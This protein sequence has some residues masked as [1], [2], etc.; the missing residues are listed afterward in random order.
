MKT[1]N[2][3]GKEYITVNERVLAFLETYPNWSIHTKLIRADADE[4]LMITEIIDDNGVLRSTGHAYE[5]ADG[6]QINKTSHVEN[7]ETSAVGRA[8]GF[9]GIGIVNSIAT[10]DEVSHA[11]AQQ[12]DTRPWLSDKQFTQAIQRIEKGEDIAPKLFKDFKMKRTYREQ[13]EAVLE[14]NGKLNTHVG[15]T[16]Y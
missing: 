16:P 4:C 10:A 6:S 2:I 14:L 12:E 1:I 13:I 7:C 9:I 15:G 8:L 3:H 11:I 5:R